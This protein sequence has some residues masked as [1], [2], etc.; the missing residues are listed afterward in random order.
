VPARPDKIT[1]ADMRA[2]G[3]SRVL[4]YCS[5]YRCSHSLAVMADHCPISS[6]GLSVQPAASAGA[7][8]MRYFGWG[9]PEVPHDTTALSGSLLAK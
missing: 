3:V 5:D 9:C 8:R 1:F 6:R 4:V 2:A 7:A